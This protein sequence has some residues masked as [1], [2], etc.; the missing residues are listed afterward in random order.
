MEIHEASWL[1]LDR[2]PRE[3]LSTYQH[4][5]SDQGGLVIGYGRVHEDAIEG[6]VS[7]LAAAL[8]RRPSP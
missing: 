7:V 5:P 2:Q 8:R 3:T 4:G 1:R 6:A